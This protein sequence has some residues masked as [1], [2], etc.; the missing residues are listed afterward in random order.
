LLSKHLSLVSRGLRFAQAAMHC[1]RP[2]G[3]ANHTACVVTFDSF[4]DLV[5]LDRPAFG[6]ALFRH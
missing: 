2:G 4:T 6:E 3:V 1:L 5:S